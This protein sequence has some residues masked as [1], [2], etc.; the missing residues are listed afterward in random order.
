LKE[1]LIRS[2]ESKVLPAVTTRKLNISGHGSPRGDCTAQS[3]V[4]VKSYDKSKKFIAGKRLH[5][6]RTLFK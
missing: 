2:G 3:E 1:R 4:C 6:F 5:D